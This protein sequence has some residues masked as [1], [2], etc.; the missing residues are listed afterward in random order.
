MINMGGFD[1]SKSETD[2]EILS[3]LKQNGGDVEKTREYL[4]KLWGEDYDSNCDLYQ[5]DDVYNGRYHGTGKDYTEDIKKYVAKMDKSGTER[6]GCV[7]VDE[8]LAEILQLLMDKY[9]F[10][11]V[12]NSWLKL[13]YYYDYLGPKK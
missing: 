8:A 5:I 1:F 4:K 7:E 13:C 10:D 11:G 6:D 3:Y 12:E 9:T 2:G